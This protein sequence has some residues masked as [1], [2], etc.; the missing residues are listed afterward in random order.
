MPAF[1]RPLA[2]ALAIVLLPALTA[3]G[4]TIGLAPGL[5]A[6]MDAPGAQLDTKAA[7]G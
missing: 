7:L 6:R 1:I 5:T 4:P 2:F 3:C